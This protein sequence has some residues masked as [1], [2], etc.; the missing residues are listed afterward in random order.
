MAGP[1]GK[2]A[3][4]TCAALALCAF[5]AGAPAQSREYA[6]QQVQ[7]GLERAFKE[8]LE[9][10]WLRAALRKE[11]W[12][13]ALRPRGV[14]RAERALHDDAVDP[15]AE[16]ESDGAQRADAHEAVRGVQAYGRGVRAVADHGD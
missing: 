15:A 12:Q 5:S 2:I 4:G 3:L 9:I 10:T 16:L 8:P 14:A 7:I 1:R 11:A 13:L 6:I